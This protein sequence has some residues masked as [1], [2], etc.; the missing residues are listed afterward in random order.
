MFSKNEEE[1]YKK[2]KKNYQHSLGESSF[3]NHDFKK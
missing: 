3:H 1:I 2:K